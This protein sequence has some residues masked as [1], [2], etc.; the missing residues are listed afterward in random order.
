MDDFT[1]SEKADIHL[2]YGAANEVENKRDETL[3]DYLAPT[4]A[5]PPKRKRDL[6]ENRCYGPLIPRN[7]HGIGNERRINTRRMV[8]AERKVA[9][10]K[11]T[12]PDDY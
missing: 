10:T 7:N 3:S 5:P 4:P 9:G 12:A 1:K 6:H 2:I 11:G 8:T